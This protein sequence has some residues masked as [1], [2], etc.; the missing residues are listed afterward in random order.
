[1]CGTYYRVVKNNNKNDPDHFRSHY[2]TGELKKIEKTNPCSRRAI[3]MYKV[4]NHAINTSK[5]YPKKGNY[6]AQIKLTG[7]HGVVCKDGGNTDSHHNWWVPNN[8][9]PNSFCQKIKGPFNE[10]KSS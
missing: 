10:Q 5:N 1:M 2:E 7:G 9:N 3:S 6:I 8:V 4:F